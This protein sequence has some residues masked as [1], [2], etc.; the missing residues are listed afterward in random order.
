[1]ENKKIEKGL[2]LTPDGDVFEGEYYKVEFDKKYHTRMIYY[3][4]KG[5]YIASG[6]CDYPVVYV[7]EFLDGKRQGQ[8]REEYSDGSSFDGEWKDGFWYE[9]THTEK[10]GKII[11]KYVNY[12]KVCERKG[13]K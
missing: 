3:H 8:G 6:R 1:M 9:G 12:L 5:K 2:I 4:G 7:G 13:T 10:D 11:G